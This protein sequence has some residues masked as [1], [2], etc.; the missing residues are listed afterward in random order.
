[1]HKQ[2][3]LE[4]KKVENNVLHCTGKVISL[5]S[6]WGLLVWNWSD[7]K[8]ATSIRPSVTTQGESHQQDVIWLE[9]LASL[10][11]E[12]WRAGMTGVTSSSKPS[13]ARRHDILL[14]F[15]MGPKLNRSLW[16]LLNI[17]IS[18]RAVFLDSSH[19]ILPSL[20]MAVQPHADIS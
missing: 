14:M 11:A 9:C 1:M 3:E 5:S 4:K 17:C 19:R 12:N 8:L 20:R 10:V 2:L 13:N 7:S 18:A 6:L 16:I 15:S